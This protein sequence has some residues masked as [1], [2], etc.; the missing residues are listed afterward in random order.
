MKAFKSRIPDG[1][2]AA[3]FLPAD[4]TDA[5]SCEAEGD[6]PFTADDI[7]VV[8]WTNFPPWVGSL[9]KLRNILV[10][11]F[12][13]K[14]DSGSAEA[15]E[16][17]IRAGGNYRFVSVPVK[18]EDETILL[19]SDKHLDAY[20]SAHTCIRGDRRIVTVTTLVSFNNRFG[21]VYFFFIRPF[22]S[23]IVRSM[24]KRTIEIVS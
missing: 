24:L 21:S 9:M 15:M 7:M 10:R 20:L 4:H 6:A 18:S 11:P 17:C 13:L 23:I 1:S 12:G 2:L 16:D 3:H 22:H 5:F 19:L 14:S 8:F